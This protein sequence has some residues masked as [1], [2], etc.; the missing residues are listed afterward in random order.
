MRFYHFGLQL[1]LA[2]SVL[3]TGFRGKAQDCPP[4]IDFETG[5]FAGWTCYTG[6]V[7]GNGV[8]IITLT[9]TAGPIAER[10]TMY[11][12]FPG[13]GLDQY[14]GFPIN[15]PNGSG[16]S[17]RLGNNFGGGEAEGIS[18]EFTIP[19]GQ[20]SYSLIYHYA[21]VFQDP[22]HEQYQQ[23]RMEIEIT[24]VTDNNVISCSSFTWIPY[25]NILPGF[26]Q[27]PHP[28]DETPVWCK[29]WTAVSINLDGNAGKTIRL[30]FKTADC[31]FRRH[32]GYAYID[33]NSECSGEF[34]G[35][36]YCPDDTLV[37]VVAPYGYQS[38]TWFNNTFTQILGG[39]QI[40]TLSPPPPPGT[41]IAVQ[42]TPYSGYGC[43]D[44]LYAKLVDTL[45]VV[46]HAGP[47]RLS[48]SH[49]PV[50]IGAPPKPGLVYRWSPA[51]GLSSA[52]IANPYAAPDTTT[53]YIVTTRHDGGGCIT[54]D[55][56]VVKAAVIDN[57]LE[58]IGNATYCIGRGDSTI[59]RVH[60]TD[61]IQWFKDNIA[62]N[63]ANQTDYRVTQ[64]GSYY[65]MLF[66]SSGCSSSTSSQE[67]NI[68]SV[69]V[70]G[71]VPGLTNQ[72]LVGNQFFF[73]NAST[74]AIGS[75]QY[76]WIFGD[77]T[78]ATTR[79]VTHTY[80]TAGDYEV[81]M[82]VSSN[83]V[84][85]DSSHFPV[86][87]FQNAIADF[88]ANPTCINLPVQFMNHTIDTMDSRVNYLWNLGNGQVSSL[89]N[90][91][92]QIYSAAGTYPVSLS[93][94]T[95]QCPAPLNVLKRNL[96]IDKP[97][98]AI[99][100]PVK[101]AVID[102]PLVLEARNFGD[103]VLWSPGT[104]L[105]TR[106]IFKPVFT[107][108]N[109]QLYTIAIKTTSGCVTVDTQVVKTVKSAEIYVPTAFT[110]NKDG[111]N[112]FLRPIL[113]GIKELRYFRIFNR[114]GQLIFETRSEGPGW[115]GT[116]SGIPQGTEVV[117]W[118]VEGV[119]VDNRIISKKGTSTLVR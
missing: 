5:T 106:T 72:C 11:S 93:V 18:Y 54:S 46:S 27:S 43:P 31:T 114:W 41:T 84:C 95:D 56:V 82:I 33:V 111:L 69:P 97:R 8:N 32:F 45:S 28:V 13:D 73:N 64:T 23:P 70:P 89:P 63:G 102:Y 92:D 71:V 26:F 25:G 24:N 68:S 22:N 29:D 52:D 101:Y 7:T 76:N 83:T 37:N 6:F 35:A 36:T 74:N 117:V 20:N 87:V 14:G 57:S 94:N 10:Q 21:V 112:D 110:P 80:T 17:I 1:V 53:T 86:R 15:C 40:L 44:T 51:A 113:I 9:P 59:L 50:P 67:I 12:S 61:S 58:L 88:A 48:C 4:N 2:G 49:N 55:T 118:M 100:Y 66:H 96:V 119:S 108:A 34:V 81:K 47:D 62:I 3:C 75:M 116:V 16:H 77:G 78:A 105:N 42:L 103:S 60:P 99:A 90:P 38:Y 104:W 19:A 115:D 91:P 85:A 98:P 79:D 109:E 30:F 107:G 65:A 39:N